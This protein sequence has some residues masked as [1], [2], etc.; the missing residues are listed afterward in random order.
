MRLTIKAILHG[1]EELSKRKRGTYLRAEFPH[2]WT[3]IQM[4]ENGKTEYDPASLSSL[5]GKNWGKIVSDLVAIGVLGTK[6]RGRE[7]TYWFPYVY[8]KALSLTQG[9]A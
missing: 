2:L 8:R 3:H 7:I 1:L 9:R 6:G 5:L 4:F